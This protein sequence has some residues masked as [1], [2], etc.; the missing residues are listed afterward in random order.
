MIKLLFA[1]LYI[2][3]GLDSVENNAAAILR[4]LACAALFS[5]FI[6]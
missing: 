6:Q 3:I 2:F 1:S 4:S 5:Y